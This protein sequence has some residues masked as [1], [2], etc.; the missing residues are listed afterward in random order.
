[1]ILPLLLALACNPP[2][3]EDTGEGA[4]TCVDADGALH[5]LGETWDA[6]DG[7]NTCSCEEGGNVE[8]TDLAC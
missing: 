3:P 1:M 4:I 8:C 5:P 7:C 6:G 2:I